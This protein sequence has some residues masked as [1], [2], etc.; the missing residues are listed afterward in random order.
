MDA[1]RACSIGS[2]VGSHVAYKQLCCLLHG[3]VLPRG[4]ENGVNEFLIHDT[5]QVL[6]MRVAGVAGVIWVCAYGRFMIPTRIR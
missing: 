6:N 2:P 3:N 4:A 5:G 1:L